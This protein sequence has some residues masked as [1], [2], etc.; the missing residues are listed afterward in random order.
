MANWKRTGWTKYERNEK[1]LVPTEYN[2]LNQEDF[3]SLDRI[4]KN[5][6]NNMYIKFKHVK[7]HS[8]KKYNES[9]ADQLAKEGAEE[10][11]RI[12]RV[13][14]FHM[15]KKWLMIVAVLLS[16]YL[17]IEGVCVK[18]QKWRKRPVI[19]SIFL[20]ILCIRNRYIVKSHSVKL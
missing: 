12:H 16:I 8:G 9:L 10:F 4:I 7:A 3:V 15:I 2:I 20:L 19:Q 18:T 1:Y 11:D 14:L 17:F 13:W 5:N 6:N